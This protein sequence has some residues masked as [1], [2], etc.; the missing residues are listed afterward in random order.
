MLYMD[1][2]VND[3]PNAVKNTEK[4]GLVCASEKLISWPG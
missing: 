1:T 3:F 4:G 2:Y